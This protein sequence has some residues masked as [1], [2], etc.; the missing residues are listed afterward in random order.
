M[1]I[2][3]VDYYIVT[4]VYFWWYAYDVETDAKYF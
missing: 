4:V 3:M 1:G 2:V